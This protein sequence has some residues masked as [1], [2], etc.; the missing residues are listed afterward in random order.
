MQEGVQREEVE[1]LQGKQ[2]KSSNPSGTFSSFGWVMAPTFSNTK[3]QSQ[4]VNSVVCQDGECLNIEHLLNVSG[5]PLA[6]QAE[7]PSVLQN[8]RSAG[9]TVAQPSARSL[10]GFLFPG[11]G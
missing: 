2:S 5:V 7:V 6:G 4:G 11:A 10:P 9:D 1:V 8:A 3:S